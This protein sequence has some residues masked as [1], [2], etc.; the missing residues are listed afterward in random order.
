MQ[1]ISYILIATSSIMMKV[2]N[3]CQK[4]SIRGF[5]L[6]W[7]VSTF[8]KHLRTL[9]IILASLR[10]SNRTT[11]ARILTL[12]TMVLGLTLVPACN[13]KF[14]NHNAPN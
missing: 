3:E 5:T 7:S 12:G 8:G 1:F 2:H 4:N 6:M 9:G 14:A 10:I 13:C 11:I